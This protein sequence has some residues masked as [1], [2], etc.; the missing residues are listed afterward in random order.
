VK[1]GSDPDINREKEKHLF[2]K[3][4]L[5]GE[6]KNEFARERGTR[7]YILKGAKQSVNKILEEEILKRKNRH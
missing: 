7:V 2:D 3:I 6:I 5:V 4:T 1:V